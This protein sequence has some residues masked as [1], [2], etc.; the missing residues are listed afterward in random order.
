MLE[1]P[2]P[3]AV[4]PPG[5]ASLN[6][7]V[8]R[9]ARALC[10]G[11][12]CAESPRRMI[13]LLQA[14]LGSINVVLA[15]KAALASTPSRRLSER[16]SPSHPSCIKPA[17]PLLP[18]DASSRHHCGLPRCVEPPWPALSHPA[19][20]PPQLWPRVSALSVALRPRCCGELSSPSRFVST[21]NSVKLAYPSRGLRSSRRVSAL[22]SA[23]S[24]GSTPRRLSIA[25]ASCLKHRRSTVCLCSSGRQAVRLF[26]HSATV[27]VV[28]MVTR[29]RM[30][31][32]QHLSA[33]VVVVIQPTTAPA[34]SVVA[35][36]HD[37]TAPAADS[38]V[39]VFSFTTVIINS[40]VII[41]DLTRQV[42]SI[43]CPMQD[44]N[45]S[46]SQL[47]MKNLKP[48]PQVALRLEGYNDMTQ[49]RLPDFQ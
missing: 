1:S 7:Q 26:F 3:L 6:H 44:S 16:A 18:V 5:R 14:G 39:I 27:A 47:I 38:A 10:S 13:P 40:T 49:Q 41:A 23:H 21:E 37:R 12:F 30:E 19:S 43:H 15:A 35:V 24:R 28:C 33:Q 20:W 2:L 48:T 32:R 4:A 11:L 36:S 31:A 29:A 42:K 22:R 46:I 25:V 17:P 9:A 34:Y 45:R 8:P